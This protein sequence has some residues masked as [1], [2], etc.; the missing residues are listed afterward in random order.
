VQ[1]ARNPGDGTGDW[2]AFTI[3]SF[4]EADWPDRCE[5]G[6]LN[7]DRWVDIVV[8]EEN[9]GAAPDALAC[10]WEQPAGGVTRANWPRHT[11]TTQYT[12]NSLDI[13]DMDQDGD[14]DPILAEHRGTKHIAVWE[15]DGHGN[16]SERRVDEGRESHLGGRVAD[17]DGDGDL[18][19]VS[20]AY[21]DFVKLHLW[22]N[23]STQPETTSAQIVASRA[24]AWGVVKAT[25][26]DGPEGDGTILLENRAIRVR[27][28]AKRFR[29]GNKDHVIT[30][31]LVRKTGG[32]LAAGDQLDGI[33]MNADEGRGRITSAR[34]A[35]DGPGRKTLHVEW[36]QGKVVQ[37]FTIWPDRPMVG[38]SYIKYG[39]N[40]VDMVN[41]VDA[42]AVYGAKAWQEARD[43]VTDETLLNIPNPHHRL[44]KDL[45]PRYPF[46]LL[47]GKDWKTLEP[48]ELTYRSHLVLGAYNRE[49]GLGFGRVFP[50][51]DANYVKLL[52][53]GF[54]VFANWQQPHRQ[55][56]GYLYAVTSGP[57]E[58]MAVG[59]TIVDG[60]HAR[61]DAKLP[62]ETSSLQATARVRARGPLQGGTV[63]PRYFTDG[64]GKAIYLTGSHTWASL[65]DIGLTNPPPAF[66]SPA[67][68][69][70]LERHHHNF[71]Q[72]WRWEFPQWT[73]R[74]KQRP[75]YC[76]PQ[77]WQR[78]GPGE[79][80]DGQVRLDL[81]KSDEGYFQRL[82]TRVQAADQS[83]NPAANAP[84]PPSTFIKGVSLSDLVLD[85]VTSGDQWPATW[86]DDAHLY[87]AWGDGTAFGYRGG[88]GD[89]LTTYLGIARVEGDP[90]NHKG[91]NVWGG[92][93]P[94]S[95]APAHCRNRELDENLKPNSSL[96]CIGG[97]LY[98]HA[99]RER[100]GARGPW[101]VS[102][103]HSSKDHGRTWTDHGVLFDEPK[104]RF[105]NVCVIQYGKGYA[106]TPPFQENYVYLYGMEDKEPASNRDVLLA[107]HLQADTRLPGYRKEGLRAVRQR[108]RRPRRVSAPPHLPGS[109]PHHQ[110]Q[111]PV[112]LVL[113]RAERVEL[114]GNDVCHRP[115]ARRPMVRSEGI[116][117]R[118][119][120]AGLFQYS[121]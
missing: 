95:D 13:A 91:C 61:A 37:E 101:S 104:G 98:L 63:N 66:N 58:L 86:A 109:L 51:Q 97:V 110:G 108:Q 102:R 69:D 100:A 79:A 73:E 21:D 31:F 59:K 43:K 38:I 27:Y 121:A 35:F 16:F 67:Y 25:L 10:W 32:Q 65:Q 75:F 18:D 1:W 23:D 7:G 36:D 71:I 72:L 115:F 96:V 90:P 6:D 107:S 20:I 94:E 5:A 2:S 40:I 24:D 118:A 52:N 76:A 33:W 15:N 113:F 56:T 117:D 22:R 112:L 53:M 41:S 64:S 88:W 57:A 87:S 103:L 19:L 8:T 28:A 34:V 17:L 44:T 74:N 89:R 93:Q 12:M 68:L 84:Y 92:Y 85:G 70:F 105:G 45:Y 30:E 83:R 26:G 48:K 111:R 78:A 55:F 50:V 49:T 14:L 116:G 42:F 77:P 46:P 81:Q 80:L 29:D 99:V 9:P 54:E 62:D 120:V 60:I 47:A 11:I 4:P 119:G 106:G 114:H 3:G 39:V 82:R